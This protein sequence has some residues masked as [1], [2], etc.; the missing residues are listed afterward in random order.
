MMFFNSLSGEIY[1]VYIPECGSFLADA[2]HWNIPEVNF[3]YV[4]NL[5]L[6]KDPGPGQMENLNALKYSAENLQLLINDI[7]DLGVIQAGKHRC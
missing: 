4:C 7:L 5:M 6:Q 1:S 2:D 3:N